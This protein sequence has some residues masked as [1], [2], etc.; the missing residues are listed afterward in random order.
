MSKFV[1]E[2]KYGLDLEN[3]FIWANKLWH[4]CII[5]FLSVTNADDIEKLIHFFIGK[6][7]FIDTSILKSG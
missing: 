4:Q 7:V 6:Y 5:N 1:Q 3:K 2:N